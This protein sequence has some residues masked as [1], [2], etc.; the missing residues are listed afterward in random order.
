MPASTSKHMKFAAISDIHGNLNALQAVLADIDREGVGRII[1][2]GDTLGGPLESAKTADLLMARGI[3]MIAGNHERQLLTLPLDKLNRSDACTASEISEAHRAWL[4]SA[5]PTLWLA[6]DVFICHGTP[7]SD[8][9]YWLETVTPDFGQHGSAGVRAAT[10]AKV[11]E[12]M[13]SGEHTR[14]ASLIV[15]GH[16]H[17]PRVVQVPSPDGG[18]EITIVNA[19]SVGLPGYD[20]EHPH[21]HWIETGSPHA[22]YAMLERT[23]H[24]WQVQLRSVPYDFEPMARLA[25]QRSRPDWAMALRTGRMST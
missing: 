16:T 3:P 7:F 4:A 8:L 18:H 22:R 12:R 2:C 9:H 24:G 19:G 20:D 5:P 21:P 14:R 6:D 1:N 13:G 11:S 10:Q 15:C 25:E 23:A 17:V